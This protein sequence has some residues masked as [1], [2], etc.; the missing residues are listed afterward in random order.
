MNGRTI[1]AGS[2]V[3]LPPA[4]ALVVMLGSN[5]LLCGLSARETADR[6][7][8]F[9]SAVCSAYRQVLLVAPPPMVWGEWV[10]EQRLLTESGQLAPLYQLLARH[11]SISFADAAPW[12]V[13]LTFDGV[14][15]SEAGHRAFA[16]GILP[17]FR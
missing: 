11:L 10:T 17:F 5:D 6:M 16:S 2:F 4:D 8:A 12:N 13:E 3:S 7:E 9:L 15:F 14:H 1:P